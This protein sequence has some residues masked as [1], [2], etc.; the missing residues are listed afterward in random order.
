[1]PIPSAADKSTA[2]YEYQY[3]AGRIHAGRL[4]NFENIWRAFNLTI[5]L[6]TDPLNEYCCGKKKLAQ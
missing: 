5:F 2:L 6:G 3:K 4:Q 1:V